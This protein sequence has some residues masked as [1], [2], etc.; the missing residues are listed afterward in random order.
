MSEFQKNAAG[1]LYES[2]IETLDGVEYQRTDFY[3]DDPHEDISHCHLRTEWKTRCSM[4]NKWFDALDM[5][6]DE[7]G[8][9]F[10]ICWEDWEWNHSRIEKGVDK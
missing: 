6:S 5:A 7:F 2:R 1:E 9:M 10:G 4:C 8:E 3:V